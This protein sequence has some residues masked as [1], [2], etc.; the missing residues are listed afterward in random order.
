MEPHKSGLPHVHALW[1]T[2]RTL[3]ATSSVAI[4]SACEVMGWAR[5]RPFRA[6]KGGEAYVVKQ[7]ALY[8]SKRR[9]ERQRYVLRRYDRGSK[10]DV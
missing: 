5:I 10:A 7:A 2:A 6:M 3:T 1:S 8:I 9:G 4:R